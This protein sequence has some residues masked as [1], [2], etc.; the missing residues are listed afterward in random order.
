[1]ITYLDVLDTAVKIGLGA[2]ITAAAGHFATKTKN[3]LDQKLEREKYFRS[4]VERLSIGFEDCASSIIR[5]LVNLQQVENAETVPS[6]EKLSQIHQLCIEAYEQSN[7][8]DAIA[9]LVGT[10]ELQR[11]LG[12]YNEHISELLEL[13]IAYPKNKENIPQAI[14][15]INTGRDA[16][17]A[18]IRQLFNQIHE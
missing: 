1:M 17:R 13:A 12:E 4:L 3:E 15:K 8:V 10:A 16:T 9:N 11:A 7:T 5:L 6:P 14:S 18:L 2:A